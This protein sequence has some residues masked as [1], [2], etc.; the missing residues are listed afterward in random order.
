MNLNPSPPNIIFKWYLVTRNCDYSKGVAVPHWLQ[1]EDNTQSPY[2]QFYQQGVKWYNSY[3]HIALI[4]QSTL[5]VLPSYC[6]QRFELASTVPGYSWI[7][8][9]TVARG[10]RYNNPG[11]WLLGLFLPYNQA[12]ACETFSHQWSFRD[13]IVSWHDQYANYVVLGALSPAL[14]RS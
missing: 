1:R 8:N 4:L 12:L 6:Y 7:R 2:H 9:W 14:L 10:I 3:I 5:L 13:L 11:L